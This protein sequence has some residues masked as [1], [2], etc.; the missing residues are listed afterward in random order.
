MEPND[1]PVDGL[2]DPEDIPVPGVVGSCGDAA[3]FDSQYR[4]WFV[5]AVE[6]WLCWYRKGG[7]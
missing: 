4:E 6:R 2:L 7:S 3:L 1:D 5:S